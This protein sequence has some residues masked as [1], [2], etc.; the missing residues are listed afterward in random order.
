MTDGNSHTER[1]VRMRRFTMIALTALGSA[2]LAPEAGATPGWAR[3][4]NMPCSG[5]HSPV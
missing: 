1:K 2:V 3:K 4:Y 5:C